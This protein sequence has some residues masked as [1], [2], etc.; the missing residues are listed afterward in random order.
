MTSRTLPTHTPTRNND[1]QRSGHRKKLLRSLKSMEGKLEQHILSLYIHELNHEPKQVTCRFLNSLDL[2]ISIENPHSPS[3]VF[4]RNYGST[5]VAE[6]LGNSLND[7]I[8]AKFRQLFIHSFDLPVSHV[9]ILQ[10][11]RPDLV[12]FLISFYF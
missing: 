2:Y 6:H 9:G 4:I 10:P 3:E 12:Y 7:I 1:T 11:D 5:H 8:K